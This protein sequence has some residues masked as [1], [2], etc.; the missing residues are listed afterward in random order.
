MNLDGEGAFFIISRYWGWGEVGALAEE[1]SWNSEGIA[2]DFSSWGV[3]IIVLGCCAEAEHD[4]REFLLPL[5][6]RTSGHECCFEASMEPFNHAI[7]LWVVRCG[8][9]CRD[10]ETLCQLRP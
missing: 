7:G 3:V 8:R 10:A 9:R 1:I 2:V 4:P 5:V 6:G